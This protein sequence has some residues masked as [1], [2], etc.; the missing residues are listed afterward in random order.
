[1]VVRFFIFNSNRGRKLGASNW[2]KVRGL[3]EKGKGSYYSWDTNIGYLTMNFQFAG[4]RSIMSKN[5]MQNIILKTER[6]YLEIISKIHFN[7]L[8]K[9]IYF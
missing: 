9:W 2:N 5:Q 3:Q 7:D 1:M 4:V 6:L 8:Y